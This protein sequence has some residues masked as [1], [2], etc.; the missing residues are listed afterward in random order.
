[1]GRAVLVEGQVVSGK[2]CCGRRSLA[3]LRMSVGGS[4]S[5]LRG[6]VEQVTRCLDQDETGLTLTETFEDSR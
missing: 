2:D 3:L 4:E 5:A 6:C 1:M